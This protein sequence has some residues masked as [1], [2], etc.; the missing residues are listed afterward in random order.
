MTGLF[1]SVITRK[2]DVTTTYAVISQN[3]DTRD[4]IDIAVSYIHL[5]PKNHSVNT[6]AKSCS[7]MET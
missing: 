1:M 6:L 3:G 5:E 4:T 2:C 7:K